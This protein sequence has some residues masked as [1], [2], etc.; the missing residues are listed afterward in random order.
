MHLPV[1]INV[2]SNITKYQIHLEHLEAAQLPL[3]GCRNFSLSVHRHTA[4][5]G[6]TRMLL[7]A[8]QEQLSWLSLHSVVLL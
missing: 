3:Q 4:L 1:F 8:H 2:F 7:V 6:C 5:K